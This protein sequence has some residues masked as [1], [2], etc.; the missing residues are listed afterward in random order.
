METPLR[1]MQMLELDI[2]KEVK[3]ICEKNNIRYF[4][5]AGTMLGAVRHG[6]FIPWDDDIDIGMLRREYEK[7]LIACQNDLSDAFFLQTWDTDPHFPFS[8]AKIRLK[9]TRVKEQ[10]SSNAEIE[11]GIFIDIFPYDYVPDGEWRRWIHSYVY[12]FCKRLLWIKKGFGK[13]IADESFKQAAK[14]HLFHLISHLFPYD[15]IKRFFSYQQQ[16]YNDIP[17]QAVVADGAYSYQ[18]ETLSVSWVENLTHIN[19]E[20]VPFLAIDNYDAYLKHIYGDYMQLPPPE[21][22]CGHSIASIDFGIY[23][24]SLT[25]EE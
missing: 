22:R 21:Q 12:F 25:K 11:D 9:G 24:D 19:F 17:T 10:F 14:Y 8:Y 3:R 20:N 13:G 23:N 6:G 16:K 7:F 2:A 15:K 1:R 18:T 4:L 5:L